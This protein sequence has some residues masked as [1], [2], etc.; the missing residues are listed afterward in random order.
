MYRERKKGNIDTK[1][2]FKS[3][4][5]RH[6]YD[7]QPDTSQ[8]S[9]CLSAQNLPSLITPFPRRTASGFP[10]SPFNDFVPKRTTF[11]S[12]SPP[13]H[14][15]ETN[16]DE[17][18]GEE[19]QE[20]WIEQ[21]VEVETMENENSKNSTVKST[22]SSAKC[23]SIRM[24]GTTAKYEDVDSSTMPWQVSFKQ[25]SGDNNGN[26]L[27]NL[28]K[29]PESLKGLDMI[30]EAVEEDDN[31]S[32]NTSEKKSPSVHQ[33]DDIKNTTNTTLN[34]KSSHPSVSYAVAHSVNVSTR[35]LHEVPDHHESKTNSDVADSLTKS[36]SVSSGSLT[37]KDN[38]SSD[39]DF[40]V[41]DY[42]SST[43]R[44]GGPPYE[45]LTPDKNEK[46][47]THLSESSSVHS[48][49]LKLFRKYDTYT[50]SK[51]EGLLGSL[52]TRDSNQ[53]SM[54]QHQQPQKQPQQ[55]QQ[56]QLQPQQQRTREDYMKD[57][58]NLFERLK[59]SGAPQPVFEHES[60]SNLTTDSSL[61]QLEKT[62]QEHIP[63]SDSEID[64]AQHYYNS[65]KRKLERSGSSLRRQESTDESQD[66]NYSEDPISQQ[67][68]VNQQEAD[69]KVHRPKGLKYISP[70]EFQKLNL[71]AKGGDIDLSFNQEKLQW[72]PKRNVTKD[73]GTGST[74]VNENELD[75]LS[76][77]YTFEYDSVDK[78]DDHIPVDK[79]DEEEKDPFDG[80]DD[81]K[82]S[83]YLSNPLYDQ[84]ADHKHSGTDA[85]DA[86]ASRYNT[87]T[88]SRLD[89]PPSELRGDPSS[90]AYSSV[91]IGRNARKV[92]DYVGQAV[93]PID[94]VSS[95]TKDT[96]STNRFVK[97]VPL[98]ASFKDLKEKS[99]FIL[100]S[101]PPEST[102]LTTDKTQWAAKNYFKSFNKR[103]ERSYF[104]PSSVLRDSSF[105]ASAFRE[106]STVSQ[107][108]TSFSKGFGNLI[109]VL[110]EVYHSE[111][112]WENFAEL[113]VKRKQLKSISRLMEIMPQ[114]LKLNV[115]N[116]ELRA[117]TGAPSSLQELDISDNLISDVAP[118]QYLVNLHTLDLSS[119]VSLQHLQ[120]LSGLQHLREL[121]VDNNGLTSLEAISKLSG[122]QKLSCNNNNISQL[123]LLATKWQNL[124]ELSL[125]HNQLIQLEGIENIPKLRTLNV[126]SNKLVLVNCNGSHE[127][128]RTLSL[129]NNSLAF[130][131]ISAYRHLKVLRTDGNL[132][133]QIRGINKIRD[134]E[135]LSIRGQLTTNNQGNKYWQDQV[136]DGFINT[137]DMTDWTPMCDIR[138]LR[139]SG[140]TISP[141]FP[142]KEPFMNL[143]VLDLSGVSLSYLPMSL[144]EFCVNLRELDLS[145]NEISDVEP[146]ISIPKLERLYLFH[147][148]LDNMGQIVEVL[149]S[150]SYLIILDLRDNPLTH[151]LYPSVFNEDQLEF[152][153][154]AYR[155]S[156]TSSK[157]HD[158]LQRDIEYKYQLHRIEHELYNRRLMY[159]AT[160]LASTLKNGKALQFLDGIEVDFKT[161]QH[162]LKEASAINI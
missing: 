74:K 130:I 70:E 46:D 153:Y 81:L 7:N 128:L 134:L 10:S 39:S 23:D 110:T 115:S 145:F 19:L 147:N 126:D 154:L 96:G 90:S 95:S 41:T 27:E 127:H 24:A 22:Q 12:S 73:F 114:L 40:N 16:W 60:A 129:N 137:F 66:E 91:V 121:R 125:N 67:N 25:S 117:V 132:S 150:M 152:P 160:V 13:Q 42:N 6:R 57:A 62:L 107:T 98:E 52:D 59:I 26:P 58:D 15:Q 79:N 143:H 157:R 155:Q 48:S 84:S 65:V 101:S 87:F 36:D 88:K 108:N 131:D 162:L 85:P 135:V 151:D 1:D 56:Q 61:N 2:S 37:K 123:D 38:V 34:L 68:R 32:N 113:D 17:I 4:L 103:G 89:E 64:S 112:D 29:P 80:I 30:P 33:N 158:W 71:A 72:Q 141:S 120:G 69:N 111:A 142:M 49:P 11:L 78:D 124:E 76:D 94:Q 21:N 28:F 102:P 35:P 31:D 5:T 3:S 109:K 77:S 159:Q 122:L 82:D 44:S 55:S 106:R 119:N 148:K 75:S 136:N 43:D 9:N 97:N 51:F 104:A 144:G 100:S 83:K 47:V 45:V 146:L 18:Y 20:E 50:N 139:F 14:D 99:K 53:S 92:S 140:N 118:F 54:K 133:I 161:Q 63:E 149:L 93:K 138:V 156:R 105:N 8:D 86:L 116:N